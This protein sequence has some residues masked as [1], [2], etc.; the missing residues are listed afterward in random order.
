MLCQWP[1]NRWRFIELLTWAQKG[2]VE[3][4]KVCLFSLGRPIRGRSL[5]G[6]ERVQPPP[7]PPLNEPHQIDGKAFERWEELHW[8]TPS[9]PPPRSPG[10]H[11]WNVKI[12]FYGL[13]VQQDFIFTADKWFFFYNL[14]NYVIQFSQLRWRCHWAIRPIDFISRSLSLPTTT[15][16]CEYVWQ[17]TIKGRL[18][19]C[20]N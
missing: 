10:D 9:Q 13:F 12:V 19:V 14:E 6:L 3:R 17:L 11:F 2:R 7:P 1:F 4:D 18:I 8:I 20:C 16:E 5:T 15:C